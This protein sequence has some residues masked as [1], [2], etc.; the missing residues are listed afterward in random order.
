MNQAFFVGRLARDIE[1]RELGQG[2][3][4]V[5]N[6]LAVSRKRRNKEGEVPVDFIPVVFWNRSAKV[7]KRFCVKGQRIAVS[8]PMRIRKYTD[9]AG[10]DRFITECIV[11]EIT[12]LDRMTSSYPEQVNKEQKEEIKEV[13]NMLQGK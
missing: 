2:E 3:V 6:A 7:V 8:G 13:V 1:L 4:V 10:N 11:S 5:N 9:D 12:L